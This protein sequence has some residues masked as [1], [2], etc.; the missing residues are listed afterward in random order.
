MDQTMPK[1]DNG[2]FTRERVAT[3]PTGIATDGITPTI[4]YPNSRFNHAAH[5]KSMSCIDC[6][7]RLDVVD[8]SDQS[9]KLAKIQ[10]QAVKDKLTA[11]AQDDSISLLPGMS[12]T[13]SIFTRT[14]DGLAVSAGCKS[15]TDCHNPTPKDHQNA[16]SA[17]CVECHYYHDRRQG[18]SQFA[19]SDP[20]N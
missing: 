18:I 15:C 10:D 2:V 11:F 4:W 17:A 14:G 12:W 19:G 7:S 8:T 9:D 13:T 16:A 20:K 5:S 3:V 6:H 1:F